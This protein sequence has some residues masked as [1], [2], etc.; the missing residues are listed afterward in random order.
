MTRGRMAAFARSIDQFG[1]DALKEALEVDTRR[2]CR[3]D[4]RRAPEAVASELDATLRGRPLDPRQAGVLREEDL[5]LPTPL[6]ELTPPRSARSRPPTAPP[7]EDPR[8]R[9]AR[10]RDLMAAW[11]A[12]FEVDIGSGSRY[13]LDPES[14][15][16][17]AVHWVTFAC[18]AYTVFAEPYLLA[19]GHFAVDWRG[20]APGLLVF[21]SATSEL[22]LLLDLLGG[23]L[24][25]YI[26]LAP[27]GMGW[28][29]ELNMERTVANYARTW[30]GIDLLSRIC[31]VQLA[32]WASNH[33]F[34]SVD[35]LFVFS[36]LK[37]L[38]V[39]RVYD[40]L[41]SLVDRDLTFYRFVGLTKAALTATMAAHWLACAWLIVLARATFGSE[42]AAEAAAGVFPDSCHERAA[43]VVNNTVIAQ[44]FCSYYRTMQTITT[45]AYGDMPATGFADRAFTMGCMFLGAALLYMS[46][47]K[48]LGATA[49]SD[50][51]DYI[52]ERNS[53]VDFM[54]VRG[55]AVEIVEDTQSFYQHRWTLS[56]GFVD[57]EKLRTIPPHMRVRAFHCIFPDLRE[58][59]GFLGARPAE[60]VFFWNYL[61]ERMQHATYM[62]GDRLRR[63]D[64][65]P[66]YDALFI[67]LHGTV[68]EVHEETGYVYRR[69][70][71]LSWFGEVQEITGRKRGAAIRA[72]EMCDV[73]EL[74]MP[75][76]NGLL[77][78]PTFRDV[79]TLLQAAAQQRINRPGIARWRH[80]WIKNKKRILKIAKKMPRPPA[81]WPRTI[82]WDQEFGIAT[83]DRRSSSTRSGGSQH[84]ISSRW[85]GGGDNVTGEDSF[86]KELHAHSPVPPVHDKS[87]GARRASVGSE[88]MAPE[89]RL[90]GSVG[91]VGDVDLPNVPQEDRGRV[92]GGG[93]LQRS[94]S[95]WSSSSRKSRL[96]VVDV[97]GPGSVLNAGWG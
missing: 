59:I 69:H 40:V 6:R 63:A 91:D 44:Y 75:V 87:P 60:D 64:D 18:A 84:G 32:V 76:I 89:T 30:L 13:V 21:L 83:P 62:P 97:P 90:G 49:N 16:G 27:G 43:F 46:F 12:R 95:H 73:L 54:K 11:K 34:Q 23:P 66:H 15:M 7:E 36:V 93:G 58:S 10:R 35:A 94:L 55:L 77:N 71:G 38:M 92:R 86:I 78:L 22:L 37:L 72:A 48:T 52:H 45:V 79:K 25:G 67:M 82:D 9:D 8:L 50:E 70:Q 31:P 24:K 56:K 88:G 4:R 29:K 14:R 74:E 80:Y 61:I 65:P 41:S 5:R 96:P 33:R 57:L 26:W 81:P 85:A 28:K 51:L 53:V 68:E 3:A 20:T 42:R 19:L 2:E 1:L 17:R 39:T 47:V